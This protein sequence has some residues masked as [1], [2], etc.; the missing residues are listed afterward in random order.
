L[1][2]DFA[3]G[4]C[5]PVQAVLCR[6]GGRGASFGAQVRAHRRELIERVE[7]FAARHEARH[8]RKQKNLQLRQPTLPLECTE[9]LANGTAEMSHSG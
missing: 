8:K 1:F 6:A 4:P 7:V 5:L 2:F 3:F 9:G